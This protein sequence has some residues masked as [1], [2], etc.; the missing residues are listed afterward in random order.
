MDFNNEKIERRLEIKLSEKF[1]LGVCAAFGNYFRIDP[2]IIRIVVL[3]IFLIVG[4]S[5]L[6]IYSSLGILLPVSGDV[7][8]FNEYSNEITLNLFYLIGIVLVL[9][10]HWN[11]I[12]L[13]DIYSYFD[14]KL[15][16]FLLLLFFIAMIIN[17]YHKVEI[18]M[19]ASNQ[20]RLTLS[21][22]RLVAGVCAGLAEYLDIEP[23]LMRILWV[24]FVLASF[25]LG[26]LCYF[27]L[28]SILPVPEIV[29]E[30]SNEEL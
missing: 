16:P 25:G 20:K 18:N 15:N 7:D 13:L 12:K 30:E 17:G 19:Q 11:V 29:R 6:L 24:M 9:L 14:N 23:N 8:R 2:V 1:L 21:K 22:K 4:Q 28:W 10:I 27:A 3:I 5:V 26:I